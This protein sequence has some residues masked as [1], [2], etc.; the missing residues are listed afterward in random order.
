[1]TSE[2]VPLPPCISLTYIITKK[3]GSLKNI[4]FNF[5]H[6]IIFPPACLRVIKFLTPDYGDETDGQV[7][8]C[9]PTGRLRPRMTPLYLETGNEAEQ[10]LSITFGDPLFPI[11]CKTFWLSAATNTMKPYLGGCSN[12]HQNGFQL[13]SKEGTPKFC[14]LRLCYA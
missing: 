13:D 3:S 6:Q 2:V 10:S 5:A 4:W 7:C 9:S 11:R 12:G 8:C 1:M 14:R